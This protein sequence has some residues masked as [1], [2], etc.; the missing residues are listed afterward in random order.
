MYPKGSLYSA[1][2]GQWKVKSEQSQG[3]WKAKR[4][5]TRIHIKENSKIIWPFAHIPMYT[6]LGVKSV[7]IHEKGF[8]CPIWQFL[9]VF[10]DGIGNIKGKKMVHGV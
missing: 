4:Q 5:V 2:M 8:K 7:Y 9:H 6:I 1:S 10:R 3:I